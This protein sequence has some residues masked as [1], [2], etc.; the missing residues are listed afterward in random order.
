MPSEN[1]QV[2][3]NDSALREVLETL[4]GAAV[5]TYGVDYAPFVEFETA[6]AGTAPPFK[7]IRG[8]VGRKWADLDSGMK[9][10]AFESHMTTDQWKDAVAWLVVNAIAKHGTRGVHFG[11]RSVAKMRANAEA[12][13]KAY[14]GSSDP[15]APRK[16]LEDIAHFGFE[17]SQDIIA[18]EASDTGD[19]LQSGLV[20]ITE[21]PD[22]SGSSD[23]IARGDA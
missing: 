16:L 7:A 20:Y 11:G 2:Q 12:F 13:A 1:V 21:E 8:W 3:F 10:A 9:D 14:E 23:V 17:H 19:L 18:R 15:Q 6:Y 5:I 4:S 22:F